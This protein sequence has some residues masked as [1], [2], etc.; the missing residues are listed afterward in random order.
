MKTEEKDEKDLKNGAMP[1]SIEGNPN[2]GT[3]QGGNFETGDGGKDEGDKDDDDD[4][5]IIPPTGGTGSNGTM[6]V[7]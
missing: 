1:T 7:G 4:E 5:I 2:E 6:P 3:E